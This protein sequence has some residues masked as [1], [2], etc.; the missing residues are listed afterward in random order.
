[1]ATY[2]LVHGAWHGGWCWARVA[3]RLRAA[4]HVVFTPTLSGVADRSHLAAHPINLSTHIEDVTSLLRWE[5]LSDVILVGH[6]YGGAVITG[7]A[8][9]IGSR[10]ATLVYLDAFIPQDGQSMLDL[11]PEDRRLRFLSG[12]REDGHMIPPIN[13][14]HFNV[15]QA[16]RTWVDAQ[17]T[18][19]PA[20]CFLEAVRR[21]GEEAAVRRHVYI[22]ATDYPA[23][24]FRPYRDQCAANPAWQVAEIATGH[25]A[26]LDDP[27]ALAALLLPLA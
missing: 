11:M 7:A 3:D 13:A 9:R 19:H 27:A 21:G 1:M 5:D 2:V 12:L 17:C 16:D 10:I 4:G 15:N 26:M 23:T 14:A 22:Q 20:G 8:A 24:P 6:S 25:D 18:P